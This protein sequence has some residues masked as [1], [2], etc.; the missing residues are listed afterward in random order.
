MY[1]GERMAYYKKRNSATKEPLKYVSIISDGMAQGHCKLPWMANLKDIDFDKQLEQHLQGVYAHGRSIGIFRT[2]HN[3][4]RTT[5]AQLHSLLLHLE[6]LTRKVEAD[7]STSTI[8]LPD[9]MY[10]QVDGG[11]EN[12]NKIVYA[13]MELLVAKKLFRKI[14]L[15]RLPVGHT[16]EDIDAKFA[17]IWRIIRSAHVLTPQQYE[18]LII[19]ALGTNTFLCEVI[20]I[21]AIPDYIQF[22]E[23]YIDP[24][25]ERFAKQKWTQLEFTFEA[26]PVSE[27]FPNGVKVTY[28]PFCADE[29]IL[30]VTD[31]KAPCQIIDDHLTNIVP[32]PKVK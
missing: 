14:V 9:T 24:E 31:S 11:P 13:M 8:P 17:K 26:V 23:K 30:I 6:S 29:A 2:F 4:K 19:K 20:D 15:T 1:M 18:E 7:G 10:Y 16:H 32:M 21:F 3:V 28:R 25:F 5:N 12:A 22:L 27:Q